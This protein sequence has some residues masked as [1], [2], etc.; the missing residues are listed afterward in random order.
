MILDSFLRGLH[1]DRKLD[2]SAFY[3]LPT[4][5]KDLER[6]IQHLYPLELTCDESQFQR[7]NPT[8]LTFQPRVIRDAAAA[9]R[10]RIQDNGEEERS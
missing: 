2:L 3:S 9:A 1:S 4:D 6:A 7:P 5:E 10:L 8:A